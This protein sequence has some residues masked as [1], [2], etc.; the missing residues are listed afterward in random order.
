MNIYNARKIASA[1]GLTTSKDYGR[2]LSFIQGNKIA[3]TKPELTKVKK[4][5]DKETAM[6]NAAIEEAKSK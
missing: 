3:L 1:I 2:V 4:L 6:F 5:L